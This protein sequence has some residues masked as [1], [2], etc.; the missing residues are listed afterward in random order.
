M[1]KIEHEEVGVRLTLKTNRTDLAEEFI[2]QIKNEAPVDVVAW[3]AD[4]TY[5]Q[6]TTVTIEGSIL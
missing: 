4:K 6:G 1:I 2:Q 5:Y 3:L